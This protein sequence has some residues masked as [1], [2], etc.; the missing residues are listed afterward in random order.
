[1]VLGELAKGVSQDYKITQGNGNAIKAMDKTE[2]TDAENI[3]H[4]KLQGFLELAEYYTLVL[5]NISYMAV[6][7][8]DYS[9]FAETFLTFAM[10]SAAKMDQAREAIEAL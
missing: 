6:N 10:E 1:M 7:D 8:Q 2:F 4:E 3:A 5:E 9:M